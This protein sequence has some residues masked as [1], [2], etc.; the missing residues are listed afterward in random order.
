MT[1]RFGGHPTPDDLPERTGSTHVE[2][3]AVQTVAREVAAMPASLVVQLALWPDE[4]ARWARHTRTD[5]SVVYNALAARKPY[6]A[7]R[8]RLAQRLDVSPGVLGHLIEARR[9]LPTAQRD[10]DAADTTPEAPVE[11]TTP[12]YPAHRTGTNPIERRAAATVAREIAAFP[13]STVVG[14]ALWPETLA[15]W[16]RERRLPASVVWAVLAGAPSA[17]VRD[18]VARRLGV[19]VRELGLLID[20]RRQEPAVLRAAASVDETD[21]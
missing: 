13:A 14:L 2:R 20:A 5:A 12:P 16:S 6:R 3:L 21:F 11:W 4:L 9:P 17:P 19:S 10:P 15:A 18:M 1:R 7:V 8:E